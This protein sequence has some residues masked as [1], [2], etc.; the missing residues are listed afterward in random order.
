MKSNIKFAVSE[1]DE[2]IIEFPKQF[3]MF[4]MSSNAKVH[5]GRHIDFSPLSW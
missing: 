3:L 4:K 1:R 2:L 5:N